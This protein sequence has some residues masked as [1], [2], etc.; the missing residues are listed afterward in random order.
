MNDH[1]SPTDARHNEPRNV[2]LFHFVSKAVLSNVH[3]GS[4]GKSELKPPPENGAPSDP[5][6]ARVARERA[7]SRPD[8]GVV[9][10]L[11]EIVACAV[12]EI[13]LEGPTRRLVCRCERNDAAHVPRNGRR[14]DTS[15][16]DMSLKGISSF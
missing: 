5:R 7:R 16:L 2:S 11:R 13:L 4:A 1:D 12:L 6:H 15:Q 8:S 14:F 9:G 10:R 3:R